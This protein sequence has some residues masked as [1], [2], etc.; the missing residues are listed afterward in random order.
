MN[1]QAIAQALRAAAEA[2]DCCRKLCCDLPP[3]VVDAESAMALAFDLPRV[4][5]A[6]AT[7]AGTLDPAHGTADAWADLVPPDLANEPVG[8]LPVERRAT[9]C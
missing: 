9:S 4:S 7:I 3:G 2:L 5:L 8:E 6:L 1:K